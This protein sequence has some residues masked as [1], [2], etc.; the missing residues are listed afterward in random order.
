[1][2]NKCTSMCI[3]QDT[4]S[5]LYM[6]KTV[7]ICCRNVCAKWSLYTCNQN[8]KSA[9]V[10]GPNWFQANIGIALNKW[11]RKCSPNYS[12]VS[13]TKNCNVSWH[14]HL[15][16]DKGLL[17]NKDETIVG[18]DDLV[19]S[20]KPQVCQSRKRGVEWL[21]HNLKVF[22]QVWCHQGKSSL[23][24]AGSYVKKEVEN[25]N[26]IRVEEWNKLRRKIYKCWK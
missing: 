5:V 8:A 23:K 21:D 7:H 26:I 3:Q 25:V 10:E 16:R 15:K 20:L 24:N 13:Y 11:M 1:M 17:R 9:N 6:Y 4:Y 2:F 18:N 14:W 12:W 19:N 22:R